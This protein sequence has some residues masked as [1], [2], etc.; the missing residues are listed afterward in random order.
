MW[1]TPLCELL[2]IPYPILQGGMA[3]VA[4]G[5]LAAAVSAAGGLGIIGAGNAPP[6]LVRRE[7][8]KVKERTDRPFGI[9]LYYMSPYIEELVDLVVEEKVPVVTT[10]AGNP[11]K[12]LPRLKEAGIKVIPVVAS[13]ALAKRLERLGVDALIAEGMECGGHIGEITTMALV[14]QIVDAVNIPVIAAGGIADGRG[15]AAALALGAAGVQM[16]TRF[17]CASECTVH[18][19][20][21]EAILKAGDRDT[22]VTGARDHY[23]RILRNKLARQFE[24][25]AARGGSWEEMDKLGAGKLRA[26]AVEGDVEYGSV[27]AG[28]IAALV[29]E[30]KPAKAILEEV[31]AEAEEVMAR[32]GKLAGL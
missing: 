3:W 1:R 14:P 26:A 20:Y 31:M 2:Q 18:P 32:L 22:V 10:G 13:V 7:I 23:V 11:G 28:Q 5:E 15:V 21:K 29:K 25:L 9:N 12:H 4:T 16:G 19:N 17:I 24:E 27:M 30:I 8:H 6:E